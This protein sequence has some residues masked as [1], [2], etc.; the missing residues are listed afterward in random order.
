LTTSAPSLPAAASVL[1]R[2]MSWPPG[3]LTIDTLILGK[4]LLNSLMTS[5]SVSAKFAV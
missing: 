1:M 5:C 3:A 4:V 2:V